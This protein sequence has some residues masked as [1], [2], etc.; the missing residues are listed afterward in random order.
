MALD[1]DKI[2]AALNA[3]PWIPGRLVSCQPDAPR[4]CA[5]GLLLR[6]AGIANERIVSADDIQ[7]AWPRYKDIFRSEYGIENITTILTIVCANDQAK[8]HDE[9]IRLVQAALISGR[10]PRPAAL[11]AEIIESCDDEGSGSLAL[12]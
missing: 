3:Y 6:Y 5:V 1:L 7:I 10:V 12:V 4:Y 11:V 2:T 9:A 8:T